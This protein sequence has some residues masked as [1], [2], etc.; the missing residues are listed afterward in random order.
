[1]ETCKKSRLW[2]RGGLRCRGRLTLVRSGF[3]GRRSDGIE[4]GAFGGSVAVYGSPDGILPGGGG[5][6]PINGGGFLGYAGAIRLGQEA[7]DL[8]G[9]FLHGDAA[10]DLGA[11]GC[12]G[13]LHFGHTALS[14]LGA[15]SPRLVAVALAVSGF[16]G[17]G[18]QRPGGGV[19]AIEVVTLVDQRRF[20]G[21]KGFV[22]GHVGKR[23]QAERGGRRPRD[24]TTDQGKGDQGEKEP[25]LVPG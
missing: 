13:H 21:G 17:A 3:P 9:L 23:A 4:D 18:D 25:H 5:G 7:V 12:F 6:I 8:S 2:N 24:G 19:A 11:A 10:I 22:Y 20:A 14:A 15:Q 1:M 16:E